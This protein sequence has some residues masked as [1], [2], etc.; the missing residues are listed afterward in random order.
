MTELKKLKEIIEIFLKYAPDSEIIGTRHYNQVWFTHRGLT[1]E[2]IAVTDPK[3]R[4]RLDEL[5]CFTD[6]DEIQDWSKFL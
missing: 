1:G 5:G 3:D 2:S 4:A 6:D